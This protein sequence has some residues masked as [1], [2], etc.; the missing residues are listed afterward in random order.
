[1]ISPICARN[2]LLPS[3]ARSFPRVLSLAPGFFLP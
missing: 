2:L 1:M 3:D